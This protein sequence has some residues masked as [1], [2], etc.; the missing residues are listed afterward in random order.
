MTDKTPPAKLAPAQRAADMQ[1]VLG[2]RV[3]GEADG[4]D[5]VVWDYQKLKLQ[6]E[7]STIRHP[8]KVEVKDTASFTA[9]RRLSAVA[10]PAAGEGGSASGAGASDTQDIQHKI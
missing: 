5:W 8:L 9:E 1:Q 6:Q 10:A 7:Y 4:L 2:M 3:M